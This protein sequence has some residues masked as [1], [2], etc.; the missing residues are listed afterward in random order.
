M[1]YTYVLHRLFRQALLT[2]INI[3]LGQRLGRFVRKTLS[4]AKSEVVH[5]ISRRPFL[6]NYNRTCYAVA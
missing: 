2:V 6:H 1:C 3:T 5:E 4:F